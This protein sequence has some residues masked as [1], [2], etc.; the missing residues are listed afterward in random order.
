MFAAKIIHDPENA[1]AKTLEQAIMKLDALNRQGNAQARWGHN[2]AISGQDLPEEFHHDYIRYLANPGGYTQT[3]NLNQELEDLILKDLP[4]EA[5]TSIPE[6]LLQTYTIT[7]KG[8]DFQIL[9]EN[10]KPQ[11]DDDSHDEKTE[12]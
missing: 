5:S 12:N 3:S 8:N 1:T 9:V 2:I 4:A 6:D 10:V 11:D 7:K